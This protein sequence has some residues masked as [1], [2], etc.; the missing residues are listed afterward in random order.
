GEG[1]PGDSCMEGSSGVR[2]GHA[3]A[4]S[5]RVMHGQAV[6]RSCMGK[7]S[8]GKSRKHLLLE[9]V[10]ESTAES[11]AGLTGVG[12]EQMQRE[13][14]K[15]KARGR[16][17]DKWKARGRAQD[18]WKARG[19]AQD[20]WKARGRAQDKWKAR[21]RAQDKWKGDRERERERASR[22]LGEGREEER[23]RKQG[24]S[25]IQTQRGVAT[26]MYRQI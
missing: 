9:T 7:Q 10:V 21:G 20:K 8:A 17:Q 1:S 12:G 19:R 26:I 22:S 23:Q 13:Q 2:A 16:A 5:Q 15:W 18:K 3:W 4:S 24:E 6:S 14:D 25:A 11:S